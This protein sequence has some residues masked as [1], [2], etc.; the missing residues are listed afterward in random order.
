MRLK[1]KEITDRKEIEEL[2]LSEKV[3]RMAMCDG[4][5]P[6]VIPTTY[7][8]RD[9]AIYIHSSKKGRKIDVLRDN[10]RV[11]FVID[12]GHQL[13]QGPLDTSCKSTIKFK[14]VIGSGRARFLED[15]EEKRMA[16]TIIME[17]MF[18]RQKFQ[19]SEEGVR[20]MAIIKVELES[21][22]GKKSGY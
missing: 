21:V 19:Y 11:C 9:G 20:D 22:T 5:T 14:S 10:S 1:E 8:Y 4:D 16:M 2:L 3:C 12:T 7:G 18:G 13:V 17:Q 6:Y 15:P